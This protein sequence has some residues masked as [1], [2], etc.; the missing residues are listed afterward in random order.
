MK[1]RGIDRDGEGGAPN[2]ESVIERSD[3][4]TS[5]RKQSS[6]NAK[7]FIRIP[8]S[9]IIIALFASTI[10]CQVMEIH[11]PK[12]EVINYETIISSDNQDNLLQSISTT[13]DSSNNKFK[14]ILAIPY[15]PKISDIQMSLSSS[16]NL[17]LIN[18][19]D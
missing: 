3:Q 6:F 17:I 19:S 13:S 2:R 14:R 12:L 8:L 18:E 1:G 16:Y 10:N 11:E 7:C 4:Y 15:V 9:I 5:N